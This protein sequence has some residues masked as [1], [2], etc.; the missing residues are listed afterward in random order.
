MQCLK[1]ASWKTAGRIYV[2]CVI[3]GRLPYKICGRSSYF[4]TVARAVFVIREIKDAI[5][6]IPVVELKCVIFITKEK[7]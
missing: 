3:I 7:L 2:Y 4:F 5:D 1:I 6:M